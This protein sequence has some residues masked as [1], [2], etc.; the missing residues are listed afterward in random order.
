M[1]KLILH[2]GTH[3]T[4]TTTLQET[5]ALNRKL[6]EKNGIIFPSL[7]KFM[8]RSLTNF[9]KKPREPAGH[10]SLTL[11]W[12]PLSKRYHL[13]SGTQPI[14]EMLSE[15]YAH[16]DKTVILSSEEFSRNQRVAVDHKVIREHISAFD[17]VKVVAVL[18]NQVGFSQSLYAQMSR[19][20]QALN[21]GRYI[22]HG[23]T[24]HQA[25]GLKL[26]YNILY[27]QLLRG[28]S[29]EEILLLSF[30]EAV[31]HEGGIVGRFLDLFGTHL[32]AADMAPVPVHRMNA[33][34]EPL[35]AHLSQLVAPSEIPSPKILDC[36]EAT[37]R[38]HFGEDK[39]SSIFTRTE[40]QEYKEMFEPM[41]RALE[42]R[43]A[44]YQ[45]DFKVAP[46]EINNDL[47]HRGQID[48]AFWRRFL[49]NSLA[50]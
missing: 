46:I 15:T 49:R 34:R 38:E 39:K 1:S 4:A 45:S 24:R 23:L 43:V 5:F 27:D 31:K 17:E 19:S 11:D 42:A 13:R 28:F 3:K 9:V 14:W 29:P 41:N 8:N 22:E 6:L 40:I 16:T 25:A 37:F 44:P 30:E 33:S 18:R 26:D 47:V 12:V 32:T 35:P 2:V 48:S 20:G 10:H 21:L 36:A 7:A 50:S